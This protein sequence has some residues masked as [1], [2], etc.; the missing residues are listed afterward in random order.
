[1]G[2]RSGVAARRRHGVVEAEL[3]AAEAGAAAA[4]AVGK[5]VAA[6]E[7]ARLGVWHGISR[8]FWAK[9]SPANGRPGFL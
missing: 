2:D 9:R 6:L 8:S 3:F 1:M 4:M 7:A 5:D